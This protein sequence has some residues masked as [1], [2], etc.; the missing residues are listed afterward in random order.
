MFK[1]LIEIFF[2][3]V[4]LL[5]ALTQIIIPLFSDKKLFWIFRKQEKKTKRQSIDESV[6]RLKSKAM[7]QK[8][9]LDESRSIIRNKR[10]ELDELD[11]NIN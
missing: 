8:R 5:I 11:Q 7:N 9:A 10:D 3:F 4:L 2:I 1:F 6:S